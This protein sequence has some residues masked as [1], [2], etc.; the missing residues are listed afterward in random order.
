[1]VP[2]ELLLLRGEEDAVERPSRGE[3]RLRMLEKAGGGGV[4]MVELTS[5]GEVKGATEVQ[6]L[7]AT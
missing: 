4:T 2:P 7:T 1:M 6:V 5:G 3:E